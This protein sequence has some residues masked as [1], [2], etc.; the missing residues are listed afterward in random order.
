MLDKHQFEKVLRSNMGKISDGIRICIPSR[1]LTDPTSN[2]FIKI[3]KTAN[4][5]EKCHL[6]LEE[7]SI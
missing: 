1:Q 5:V 2:I 7:W 4:F 6:C 3:P